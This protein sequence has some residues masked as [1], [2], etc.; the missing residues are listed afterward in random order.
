MSTKRKISPHPK[1]ILPKNTK[2]TKLKNEVKIVNIKILSIGYAPNNPSLPFIIF[3]KALILKNAKT[4]TVRRL[5]RKNDWC[6]TWVNGVYPYHHYHSNT[7]EMLVV[8]AGSA[9]LQIGGL[10]GKVF[11]V[12]QGDVLF[13]PAGVS[14][15]KMS[16][17]ADFKTIGAYPFN[18]K[19]N[20][21]YLKPQEYERAVKT[22]KKV[23]L[24]GSDPIYGKNGL[25][26][27]FWKK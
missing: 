21:H 22:I 17:S 2:I 6:R 12:R 26:M 18:L 15:K 10:V 14:H 27:E 23:K 7:H 19:Y 13:F 1:Q 3:K 25:L 5:I 20:M 9:K 16:S 24:P 11:T 8:F 4:S